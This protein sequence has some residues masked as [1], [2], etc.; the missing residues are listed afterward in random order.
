MFINYFIFFTLGSA[1]C[2]NGLHPQLV[3]EYLFSQSMHSFA[4]LYEGSKKRAKTTLGSGDIVLS[5]LKYMH[6][7][8][9][10]YPTAT[11]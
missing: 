7:H 9:H 8:V 1:P 6:H 3:G 4:L 10:A 11:S 5:G 2:N